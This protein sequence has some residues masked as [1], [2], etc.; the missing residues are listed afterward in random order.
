MSVLE[1]AVEVYEQITNP[2]APTNGPIP[3]S[4]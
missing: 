1:G 3:L 4:N 2:Q